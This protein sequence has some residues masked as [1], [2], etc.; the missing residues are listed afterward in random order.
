SKYWGAE[1][2]TG[3]AYVVFGSPDAGA[4]PRFLRGDCSGDGST[5]NIADP[6]VLLL[7]NFMSGP[8]PPCLAACDANGDGRAAGQVTDAV[9][10]LMYSFLGGPAPPEPFPGC[11]QGMD[12][13][14]ALGCEAPPQGCR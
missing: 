9:Y 2:L 6:V 12:A 3:E 1:N 13:D 8:R 4:A 7:Y 11:G 10:L 5:V 14:Q